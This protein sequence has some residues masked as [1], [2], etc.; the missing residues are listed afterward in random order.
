MG[1]LGNEALKW[2]R[3]F[4][5]LRVPRVNKQYSSFNVAIPLTEQW[6]VKLFRGI[7]QYTVT[8]QLLRYKGAFESVC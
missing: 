3:F 8:P 6:A 2:V 4:L 7:P 5:F 1:E